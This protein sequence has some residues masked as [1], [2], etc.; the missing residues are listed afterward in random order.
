MAAVWMN[1]TLCNTSALRVKCWIVEFSDWLHYWYLKFDSLQDDR[2]FSLL[3]LPGLHLPPL[4][5]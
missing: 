4:V 1:D 5:F 3:P 2:F